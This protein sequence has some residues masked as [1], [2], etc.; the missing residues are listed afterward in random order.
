MVR[1]SEDQGINNYNL[2]ILSTFLPFSLSTNLDY[3]IYFNYCENIIS[4]D[5]GILFPYYIILDNILLIQLSS[6]LQNCM[7]YTIP[8]YIKYFSD[9][10]DEIIKRSKKLANTYPDFK[11]FFHHT[12]ETVQ[13]NEQ[14][15]FLGFEPCLSAFLTPELAEK[16]INR[17]YP[18]WNKKLEMFNQWPCCLENLEAFYCFFSPDGI[19]YFMETGRLTDTPANIFLT[20]SPDDRKILLNHLYELLIINPKKIRIFDPAYFPFPNYASIFINPDYGLD[21]FVYEENEKSPY[22]SFSEISLSRAFKNFILGISNSKFLFTSEKA[23]ELI[24]HYKK[25]L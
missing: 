11:D 14:F 24:T 8:D 5:N 1:Y 16:Y 13:K 6:D 19:K 20:L 23:L 12:L 7:V 4:Y 25:E 17:T 3:N 18:D 22:L 2:E 10:F 9:C 21:Y 15:Y